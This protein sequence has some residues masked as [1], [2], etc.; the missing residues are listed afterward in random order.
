[1]AIS[2]DVLKVARLA[3]LRLDKNDLEKVEARFSAILEHFKFLSEADTTGVEPL[4]HGLDEMTLRP[5]VPEAPLSRDELL[6]NAP[7]SFDD[8]FRLPKVVGVVE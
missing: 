2:E 4:F 3:R 1:M 8:S 6:K 7:E 5:D